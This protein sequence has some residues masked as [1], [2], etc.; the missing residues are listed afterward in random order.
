MF[1]ISIFDLILNRLINKIS[2]GNI[3]VFIKYHKITSKKLKQSK[4]WNDQL[5]D[6]YIHE[7]KSTMK[8]SSKLL[9]YYFITI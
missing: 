7:F 9:N 1:V 6:T 3:H 5:I 8:E 2:C 4:M